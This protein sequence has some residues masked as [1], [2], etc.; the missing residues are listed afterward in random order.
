MLK[1]LAMHLKKSNLQSTIT[2]SER[3][4]IYEQTLRKIQNRWYR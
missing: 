2:R 3:T 4:I 1:K